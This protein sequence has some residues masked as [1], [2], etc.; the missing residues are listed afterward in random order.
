MKRSSRLALKEI[1]KE[2]AAQKEAERQR[3]EEEEAKQRVQTR[4]NIFLVQTLDTRI[5]PDVLRRSSVNRGYEKPG[6]DN[7]SINE[8]HSKIGSVS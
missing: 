7:G 8:S 6:L 1:E 5:I 4:R 2:E 3:I